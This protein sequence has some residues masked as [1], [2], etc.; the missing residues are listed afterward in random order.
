[1]I[2]FPELQ[3]APYVRV[4]RGEEIGEA[5]QPSPRLGN[6]KGG[7]ENLRQALKLVRQLN[8]TYFIR[9]ILWGLAEVESIDGN[10]VRAVILYWAGRNISRS[11]GAWRQLDEPAFESALGE[12]AFAEAVEQG[13]AMTME[14]A[15]AYALEDQST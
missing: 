1:M 6:V 7:A 2:S 15:I 12:S 10:H 5:D 11:I 13:R 9:Y 14:Q 3:L 4:E 8:S